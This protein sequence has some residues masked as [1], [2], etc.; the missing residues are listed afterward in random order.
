MPPA[1][2]VPPGWP[3]SAR[4]LGLGGTEVQRT[5][6]DRSGRCKWL[7]SSVIGIRTQI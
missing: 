5:I 3:D 1:A 6:A 4:T 2:N 7:G